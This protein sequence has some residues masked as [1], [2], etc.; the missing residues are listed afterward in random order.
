MLRALTQ[1]LPPV[2][3]E[4]QEHRHRRPRFWHFHLMHGAHDNARST[5][6][7]APP[8]A[9]GLRLRNTPGG[10]QDGPRDQGAPGMSER[11]GPGLRDGPAPRGARSGAGVVR[12]RPGLRF[13]PHEAR[14]IALRT[15][16]SGA[17]ADSTS[18]LG[19]ASPPDWVVVQG[20]TTTT[21][22]GA[23]A[24]FHRRIPLAHVEAGLRFRDISATLSRRSQPQGRG[25]PVRPALRPHG[26]RRP[27]P[28]RGRHSPRTGSRH[29]QHRH[30]R[31]PLGRIARRTGRI[32]PRITPRPESVCSWSRSTDA[33]ASVRPRAHLPGAP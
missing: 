31:P 11:R 22:A 6:I 14:P 23:F 3:G 25:S 5:C 4:I 21:L 32:S 9:R 18:I 2:W 30:R 19:K 16:W 12:D 7:R 24:A 17:L 26:P 29:R 1:S 33:R 15:S 8:D 28:H 10:H 13:R 27:E 20:D